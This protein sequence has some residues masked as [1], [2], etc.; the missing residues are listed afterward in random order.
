MAQNPDSNNYSGKL[1]VRLVE[2]CNGD[3]I[4]EIILDTITL[5]TK[6][7]GLF[8][9]PDQKLYFTS[10][11]LSMNGPNKRYSYKLKAG[12]PHRVLTTKADLVGNASFDLQSLAVNF[13]KE[14]FNTVPR[15]FL[16]R[17]AINGTYYQVGMSF[18]FLEQRIPDADSV[19]RTMVWDIGTFNE[20]YLS[21]NMDGDAYVFPYRPEDFYKSL[22]DFLGADTA[23]VGLQRFIGDYPVEVSIVACGEELRQYVYNNDP[24][25]GFAAGDN[26]FT[27]IDDATAFFRRE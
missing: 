17:P 3:S 20:D 18:S 15:R 14:Y 21:H 5:H 26:E 27:L 23:I 13:S 25:N 10:E 19:L 24:T 9:S 11:P 7:Q 4:R 8:Y 6:Q 22:K 2:Y 16:F 12:M 1:D